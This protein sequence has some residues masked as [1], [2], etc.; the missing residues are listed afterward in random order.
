MGGQSRRRAV[1]RVGSRFEAKNISLEAEPEYA[2]TTKRADAGDHIVQRLRI[3][4]KRGGGGRQG[5]Y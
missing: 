1:R 5:G 4:R 2:S 3:S